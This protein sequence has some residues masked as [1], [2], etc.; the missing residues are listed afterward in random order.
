MDY[1]LRV[2]ASFVLLRRCNVRSCQPRRYPYPQVLASLLF[3]Y[4]GKF[5][6]S[7]KSQLHSPSCCSLSE[8]ELQKLRI[9]WNFGGSGPTN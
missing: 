2:G 9:S 4:C 7:R 5:F 6:Q 1:G 8:N 3:Y